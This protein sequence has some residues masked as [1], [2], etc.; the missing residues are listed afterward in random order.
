M[1]IDLF[2]EED[3]DPNQSGP[4]DRRGAWVILKVWLDHY[5]EFLRTTLGYLGSISFFCFN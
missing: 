4:A 3:D 2:S 1:M 5:V